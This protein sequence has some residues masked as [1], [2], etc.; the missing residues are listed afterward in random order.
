MTASE[1]LQIAD[2]Q[3]LEESLR[4]PSF[5]LFKHSLV[6]P[7]SERAFQEYRAFLADPATRELAVESAWIDVIGQRPLSRDVEA[8]TEIRHES[9]QAILFIAGRPVWNASHAAITA[10]S[11]ADAVVRAQA[12]AS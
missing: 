3:A 6:C 11:L 5:L 12:S 2:A 8:R 4:S 1:P 9:P 10:A 7:V